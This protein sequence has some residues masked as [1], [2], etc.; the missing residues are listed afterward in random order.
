MEKKGAKLVDAIKH[1]PHKVL[2][3]TPSPE[4]WPT[5]ANEASSPHELRT[6]L[7]ENQPSMLMSRGKTI[8]NPILV[9]DNQ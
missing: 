3:L 6:E 5:N 1:V 2:I 7:A 8:G 9:I 4:W